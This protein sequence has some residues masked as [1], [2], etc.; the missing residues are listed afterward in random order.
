M[1]ASPSDSAV[2]VIGRPRKFDRAAALERALDVF[3]RKGFAPASIAELCAA[4][5]I[6]PPSLYAAFGNKAQLFLE[7]VDHYERTYWDEA[8]DTLN[9][10][11]E[12][13]RAIVTFFSDA[14]TILTTP[15]APCGCM[16]AVGAINVPADAKDVADALKALREEGRSLFA[17]RLQQGVTDGQLAE[18]F[19]VETVGVTLNTLLQGMSLEAADGVS[20]ASLLSIATCVG[21]LLS[22]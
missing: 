4:M 5:G 21:L 16:V 9:R 22:R 19:D 14:A 3:W 6:N 11:P 7:A 10:D 18:D 15:E 20:H 12:V 17:K 8:W 2:R 13:K 1:S